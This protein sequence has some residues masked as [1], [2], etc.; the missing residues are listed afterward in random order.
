MHADAPS[1]ERQRDATRPDTQLKSRPGA[2]QVGEEVDSRVQHRRIEQF[3]P[4]G[5]VSLG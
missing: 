5:L 3:G 1:T 2:G 4:Q